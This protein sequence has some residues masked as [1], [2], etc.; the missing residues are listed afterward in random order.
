MRSTQPVKVQRIQDEY[1]QGRITKGTPNTSMETGSVL[2]KEDTGVD[3][4]ILKQ[5]SQKL[6]C[7]GTTMLLY[8]MR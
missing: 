2:K 7:S 5:G 3:D 4:S 1:D 6:Y 8:M